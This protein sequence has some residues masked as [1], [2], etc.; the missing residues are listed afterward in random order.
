MHDGIEALALI[1]QEPTGLG[2]TT[3]SQSSSDLYNFIVYFGPY[4]GVGAAVGL[5]A[6][7]LTGPANVSRLTKGVGLGAALGVVTGGIVWYAT[8]WK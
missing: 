4:A 6:A 5:G 8:P 1:R 3:D 2:A 7:V